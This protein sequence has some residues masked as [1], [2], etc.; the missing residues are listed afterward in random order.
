MNN[1]YNI[2]RPRKWFV[3]HIFPDECTYFV[4]QKL[5]KNTKL[6]MNKQ[7]T[8]IKSFHNIKITNQQGRKKK[9]TPK[10]FNLN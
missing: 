6:P 2:F 9:E 8:Q 7:P 4:M 3:Y 10:R 1:W 5:I